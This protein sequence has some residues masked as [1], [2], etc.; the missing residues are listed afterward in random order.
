RKEFALLSLL[1]S[2]QGQVLTHDQ[3][4]REVW[5]PS[6]QEDTHYL[7]VL[8]GNLRQKLGD[9]PMRP[10]FILTVQGVGYRLAV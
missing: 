8:V 5:G 4:L 10:R 2:S 3:I 7:R 1:V 9:D 6:H